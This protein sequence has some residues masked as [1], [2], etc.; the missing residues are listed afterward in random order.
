MK[1]VN[2]DQQV[3]TTVAAGGFIGAAVFIQLNSFNKAAL[4]DEWVCKLASQN[5]SFK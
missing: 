2:A 3:V 5:S 4:R 1:Q